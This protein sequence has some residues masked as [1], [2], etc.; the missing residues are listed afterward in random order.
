MG[1]GERIIDEIIN[2]RLFTMVQ[3]ADGGCVAVWS[4]AAAEQLEAVLADTG[5]VALPGSE[6]QYRVVINMFCEGTADDKR[7]VCDAVGFGLDDVVPDLITPVAD[8]RGLNVSY[9]V[10]R[11]RWV[12]KKPA[13]GEGV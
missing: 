9:A 11:E 1:L 8:M 2:R 5:D 13:D 10:Y 3:G 4:P 12:P 6:L 7:A